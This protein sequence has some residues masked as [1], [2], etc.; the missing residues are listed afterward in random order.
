LNYLKLFKLQFFFNKTMKQLEE[1]ES[2]EDVLLLQRKIAK[3]LQVRKT[4]TDT[5]G[6][7]GALPEA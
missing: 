5:L 3:L 6:I 1:A 4:I 7:E 2:E